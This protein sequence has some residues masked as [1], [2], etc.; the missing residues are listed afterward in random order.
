M[1]EKAKFHY[2]AQDG[3][4][5]LEGSEEFVSKHFESLTDIVRVMARHLT[6][7]QKSESNGTSTDIPVPSAAEPV[8]EGPSIESISN[9]LN[10]YSEIN[11]KLKIVAEIPGSTKKLQMTNAALIYCYGA[12]LMGDEQVSSKEIRETCEE[13]GCIDSPN[14]AKIFDDKTVFLSD[15]IKGGAK[16]IKLTFQGRKKAKELLANA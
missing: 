6:V 16:Q 12:A 9:Y 11:G 3:I 1:T 10:V 5:E 2:S 4:L 7:E 13:H 14:F 8:Q 15:G